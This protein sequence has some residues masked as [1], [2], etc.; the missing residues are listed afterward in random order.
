MRRAARSRRRFDT[1][2]ARAPP[3]P[4]NRARSRRCSP[5]AHRLRSPRVVTQ[6]GEELR[7]IRRH[8]ALQEDRLAGSW[9]VES[10]RGG[11]QGLALESAQSL[12][13][14]GPCTARQLEAPAVDRIADDGILDVREMQPDL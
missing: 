2:R 8:R 1:S 4:A 12:A 7:E 14:A 10:E 13:E 9:M 5:P 6:R 3:R 11:M